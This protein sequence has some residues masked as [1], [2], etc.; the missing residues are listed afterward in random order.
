MKTITDHSGRTTA[1]LQEAISLC[2]KGKTVYLIFGSDRHLK[3]VQNTLWKHLTQSE[4]ERI[5][6]KFETPQS[7]G[8]LCWETMTLRNSHP[9]CA[10]LVDHHL[11]ESKF[12]AML[13]MLHR[14]D[15]RYPCEP[16]HAGWWRYTLPGSP[17][18]D[19]NVVWD[20]REIGP[21]NGFCT[22]RIDDTRRLP[23]H[24][25][26]NASWERIPIDTSSPVTI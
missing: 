13:R 12:G 10:V 23:V 7:V 25:I 24:M 1:M 18:E 6:V 19:V 20:D 21:R 4:T 9:N 15:D 5:H 22:V 17:P 11:I 3:T 16:H 8:N 2:I 14:F 26:H